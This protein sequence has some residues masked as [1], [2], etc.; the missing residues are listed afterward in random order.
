MNWKEKCMLSH[1]G[2]KNILS[3]SVYLH[4]LAHNWL[5]NLGPGFCLHDTDGRSG[6][7]WFASRL[8][9]SAFPQPCADVSVISGHDPSS[10]NP[11]EGQGATEGEWK[12]MAED[13]IDDAASGESDSWQR[14]NPVTCSLTCCLPFFWLLM[15]NCRCQL[16][17]SH[18]AWTA[19]SLVYYMQII[20]LCNTPH[21]LK[22]TQSLW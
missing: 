13:D 1:K 11:W 15:T 3:V 7:G 2:F 8:W 9:K 22:N 20:S 12:E 6:G 21:A 4:Q 19:R 18:D 17:I 16:R 10:L 14:V 5:R